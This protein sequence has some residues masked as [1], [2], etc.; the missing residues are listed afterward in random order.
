MEI[1]RYIDLLTTYQINTTVIA[2]LIVALFLSGMF[3]YYTNDF[4]PTIITFLSI[5]LVPILTGLI[6]LILY[7]FFDV[8]P[9]EKHT[10]IFWFSLFINTTNLGTLIGRYSKE[11]LEKD[12][13]IDY[14]TRH[15]FQATLNLFITILL[16]SL[17][18]TAFVET[19]MVTI[20][21]STLVVSTAVIWLNHLFARFLLKDK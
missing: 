1:Y 7:N 13:D 8:K 12:F 4:K 9:S 18:T 2:L 3:Y 20:I 17:A 16:L 21:L 6:L 10:I 5:L 15:H 11:I 14:V 19:N